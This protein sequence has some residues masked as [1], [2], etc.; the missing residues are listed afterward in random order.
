[1]KAT[2]YILIAIAWAVGLVGIVWVVLAIASQLVLP[3][4]I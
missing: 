1:V 3:I 2:A 4:A